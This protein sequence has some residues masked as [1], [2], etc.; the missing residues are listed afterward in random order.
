MFD[1]NTTQMQIDD[2]QS[3]L[4]FQED[5]LQVMSGQMAEQANELLLAREH[6]QLLNQK[7]NE[8]MAQMDVKSSEPLDEC[9]PHY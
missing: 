2:L 6:I 9:P 8:L 3:R 5:A 1:Q 7:L 4:A